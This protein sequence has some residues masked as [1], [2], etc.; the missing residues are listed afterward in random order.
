MHRD[1]ILA[2][3]SKNRNRL[4]ETVRA[5]FD[6]NYK[7]EAV[8]DYNIIITSDVL[9]EGVNLHRANVVVNYDSP[10]NATRLMQRIG[11][12]NRIGSK[13]P[14][15][16]NYMFYPSDPGD[17]IISLKKNSLIKLQ[18]FHSALGEDT[19][20][21][22]HE[23]MVHEFHLFN[24][25]V[26]DDTD[27]SLELLRE[28]RKLHDSNPTLYRRIKQLPCKSRCARDTKTNTLPQ[29]QIHTITYLSSPKKKAFYLVGEHIRELSFLEAATIMKAEMDE[30]AVPFCDNM[31]LHYEQV[32]SAIA[33]YTIDQQRQHQDDKPKIGS[34]DNDAKKAAAFLRDVRPSLPDDEARKTVD[35]LKA[36]VERGKYNQLA[37]NLNRLSRKHKKSPLPIIEIVE[38]LEELKARYSHPEKETPTQTSAGI[39]ADIVL[40]E[41]FVYSKH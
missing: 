18:S 39:T 7:G 29:S 4:R 26:Q 36:L 10:W 38:Q 2:V 23:E 19:R 6:A 33:Q 14:V 28:V 15:I 27:R 35:V 1:D 13:A 40:S 37:D 22:S 24:S 32:R 11:R 20:I 31:A 21:Y 3:F 5:N 8:D 41:T 25:D 12:V 17:K 34:K 30:R 16:Y 9:A